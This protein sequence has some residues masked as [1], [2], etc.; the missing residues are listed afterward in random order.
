MPKYRI[1]P[2]N[3]KS[4]IEY[5]IYP[6]PMNHDQ[7]ITHI[8][9]WRFGSIIIEADEPPDLEWQNSTD[10]DDVIEF[11]PDEPT[12]YQTY[13]FTWEFESSDDLVDEEWVDNTN[14]ELLSERL[15]KTIVAEEDGWELGLTYY[16]IQCPFTATEITDDE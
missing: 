12:C 8:Q 6:Y 11:F 10:N 4:F 2:V 7:D 14:D 5:E 9:R 15:K 16:V 13:P 1:E 3:K